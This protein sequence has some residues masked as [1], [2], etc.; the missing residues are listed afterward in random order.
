MHHLGVNTVE[1]ERPGGGG[2][3]IDCARLGETCAPLLSVGG[4]LALPLQI[5]FFLP[6]HLQEAPPPAIN[7]AA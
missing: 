2:G 3:G 7:K 1:T 4:L 5:N 6:P